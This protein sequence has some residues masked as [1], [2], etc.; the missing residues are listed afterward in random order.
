MSQNGR[1]GSFI[2]A[3]EQFTELS[4]KII[5]SRNQS[6]TP[7]HSFSA[8][9][10]WPG[11][12]ETQNQLV[13][14]ESTFDRINFAHTPYSSHRR[15]LFTWKVLSI[16]DIAHS[17][18]RGW[19]N[20]H[21]LFKLICINEFIIERDILLPERVFV[22]LQDPLATCNSRVLPKIEVRIQ[23]WT[24]IVRNDPALSKWLCSEYIQTRLRMLK[25]RPFKKTSALAPTKDSEVPSPQCRTSLPTFLTIAWTEASCTSQAVTDPW[26]GTCLDGNK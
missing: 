24:I 26:S 22:S 19:N 7:E 25:Q 2:L 3:V 15:W 9:A 1:S 5:K 23:E 11:C 20:P 16:L 4:I 14:W 18:E 13:Y 8:M 12:S 10:V 21:N 6:T 17:T